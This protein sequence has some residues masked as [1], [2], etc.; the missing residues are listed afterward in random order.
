MTVEGHLKRFEKTDLVLHE[1]CMD[2]ETTAHFDW[3]AIMMF[4]GAAHLV[5]REFMIKGWGE[6]QGHADRNARARN[7]KRGRTLHEAMYALYD[8]GMQARY[9]EVFLTQD[10][11]KEAN[12]YY[13]RIKKILGVN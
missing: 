10:D 12:K 13:N 9:E 4:Y 1:K 11:V 3:I 6:S 5:E 8:Y 2:I 7:L